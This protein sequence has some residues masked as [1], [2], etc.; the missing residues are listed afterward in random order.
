MGELSVLLDTCTFIWMTVDPARLSRSAIDVISD[1]SNRRLF[2]SISVL[3]MAVKT[4][5][6]KLKL[7]APLDQVVRE[8]LRNGVVTE[9]ALTSQHAIAVSS[10]P[11]HHRDPFDRVLIAQAIEE[12]VPIVTDDR[13]FA[14]YGH[15]IIW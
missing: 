15:P 4:R 13:E 2:S 3:E 1:P 12:G 10:L 7:H 9:L 5:L 6:G 11:M 8:G 14:S